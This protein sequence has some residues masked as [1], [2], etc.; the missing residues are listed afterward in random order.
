M[1]YVLSYPALPKVIAVL[2]PVQ[3]FADNQEPNIKIAVDKCAYFV[4][5]K[6]F[7]F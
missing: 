6:K 7:L 5:G 2:L 1:T 3:T 4:F